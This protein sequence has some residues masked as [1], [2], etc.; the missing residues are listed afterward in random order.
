MQAALIAGFTLSVLVSLDT[1]EEARRSKDLEPTTIPIWVVALYHVTAFVCLVSLMYVVVNVTAVS[2]WAPQLA[3][4]GSSPEAVGR[5]VDGIKKERFAVYTNFFVGIISFILMC[6]FVAWIL[7]D[8]TSATICSLLGIASLVFILVG[9]RE[10]RITFQI[11]DDTAETTASSDL[12]QGDAFEMAPSDALHK[13]S[14]RPSVLKRASLGGGGGGINSR[15]SFGGNTR[16]SFAGGLPPGKDSDVGSDSQN[17]APTTSRSSLN[18]LHW[19]RDSLLGRVSDI[20]RSLHMGHGI[21][22]ENDSII[23]VPDQLDEMVSKLV[24]EGGGWLL[25]QGNALIKKATGNPDSGWKRRWVAVRAG[26]LFYAKTAPSKGAESSANEKRIDLAG[27]MLFTGDDGITIRLSNDTSGDGATSS[28]GVK[29][30]WKCEST[31]DRDAWV[32][33]IRAGISSANT[34]EAAKRR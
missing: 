19:Q 32:A 3:L 34:R 2:V 26:S 12:E 27:L 29:V 33:Y 1:T 14:F 8:Y 25:K 4:R 10:K 17:E 15:V 6:M 18:P 22:E 21:T 30:D 28:T 11:D 9:A 31:E 5:A 7:M 20:G 16:V 13:E 23:S 24:R